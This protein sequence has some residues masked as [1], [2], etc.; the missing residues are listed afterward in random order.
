MRWQNVLLDFDGVVAIN[1]QE[2]AFGVF[3]ESFAAFG[4]ELTIDEMFERYL[5]WRGEQILENVSQV[6]GVSVDP[7]I[8]KPV[9]QTIHHRLLRDVRKDSSLDRLLQQTVATYICSANSAGSI[10][11]L[12]RV[13]QI[14][15]HFP[16][17]TVFGQRTDCRNKPHPDIYLTCLRARSLDAVRTCAVEDS[18]VG[19]RAARA[20][21]LE[22]YGMVGGIPAHLRDRYSDQLLEAGARQV[23]SDFGDVIGSAEPLLTGQSAARCSDGRDH[24]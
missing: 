1:T 19:V 21:G 10:E 8:L 3:V 22:V 6:H 15:D 23:I 14:H 12:L 16:A 11:N 2:V 18:L 4:V 7:D 24:R 9:R 13:L 20:A 17:G 5:G